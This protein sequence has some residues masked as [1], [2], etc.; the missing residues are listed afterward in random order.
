MGSRSWLLFFIGA[1][2]GSLFMLLA[3]LR[4]VCCGDEDG[5]PLLVRYKPV[6]LEFIC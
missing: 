2:E 5:G 3:R 4:V 6:D 1:E